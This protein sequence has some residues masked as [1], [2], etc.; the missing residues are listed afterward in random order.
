M[1]ELMMTVEEMEVVIAPITRSMYVE[2][3]G[4]VR[5]FDPGL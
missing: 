1:Q 2:G 5:Y 4:W 3:Y